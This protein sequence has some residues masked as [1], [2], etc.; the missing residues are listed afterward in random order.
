MSTHCEEDS[1]TM[2]KVSIRYFAILRDQRGL[3]EEHCNT[4]ATTVGQ[5]Y[6]ELQTNFGLTPA[7]KH[8][9]ASVNAEFVDWQ[10]PI[11]NNDSVAFIPPVAGG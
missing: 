11:K 9:R 10:H 6:A 4:D 5:L 8:L 2:T 1:A 7:M 3:A